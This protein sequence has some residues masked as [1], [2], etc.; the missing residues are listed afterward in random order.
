[1]LSAKYGKCNSI[2]TLLLINNKQYNPK[3]I[4]STFRTA[5]CKMVLRIADLD[6][7]S[8]F[9]LVSRAQIKQAEREVRCDLRF[10]IATQ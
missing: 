10:M 3:N 4:T 2:E 6:P 8:R 7:V 9:F 5:S 1:M